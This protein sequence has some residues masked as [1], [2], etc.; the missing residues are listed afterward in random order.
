[1]KFNNDT[2]LKNAT[3][4]L[5]EK[6]TGRNMHYPV[7]FKKA[8]CEYMSA[9]NHSSAHV[10]FVT[11][12]KSSTLYHWVKQFND[13]LYEPEGAY[14]VSTKSKDLN[15]AIILELEQQIAHLQEKLVIIN[16]ATDLG[17]TIVKA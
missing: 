12:I 14:N 1:V 10:M 13:G 9:N 16:Q 15:R 8:V 7:L 11:E 2:D 5:R 6:K 3:Q 4:V 17:L